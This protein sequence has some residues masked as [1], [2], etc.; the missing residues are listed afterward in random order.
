MQPIFLEPYFREKIW[1]G[2][3]LADIFHYDIPAGDI[4]EA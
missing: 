1:G 2:R 3:K 4:G